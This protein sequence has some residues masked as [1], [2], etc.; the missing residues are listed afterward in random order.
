MNPDLPPL[1]IIGIMSGTSLDGVDI[2]H[3]TFRRMNDRYE[4]HLNASETIPYSSEWSQLLTEAPGM[5]AESFA[6]IHSAYG[7]YLGKLVQEFVMEKQLKADFV[8]SHGHTVFHQPGAGFT[9]QIGSGAT[10]A[11]ACKT[12][13]IC[14]FRTGD[15]ALGGQGAPLVPIG[16][17]LLFGDYYSCINLGGFANISFSENGL[18]KAFDICPVNIILNRLAGLKGLNYDKDGE[19]AASGTIIPELLTK[20]NNIPYYQAPPPK[21]L[22]REW[23]ENEFLPLIEFIYSPEDLLHTVSNHISQKISVSCKSSGGQSILVT[24]GGAKNKYLI[25]LLK[26]I[27]DGKI[28]IPDPSIIDFKEALIFAFLGYLRINNIPNCLASVT[29]ASHNSCSGA[30]YLY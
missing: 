12:S 23:L 11:V 14:D 18:R 10:L 17:E 4:Y 5:S 25:S 30:I 3:C 15:V 16:D 21:S 2:A 22:G 20:L 13:V 24:G 9:T 29:G 27:V 19:L 8:A 1:N 26:E 6:R 7:F 28:V